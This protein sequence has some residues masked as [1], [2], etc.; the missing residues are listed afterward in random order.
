MFYPKRQGPPGAAGTPGAPGQGVPTGGTPGQY[1]RKV[2]LTD[3]A[4]GWA[5]ASTISADLGLGTAAFINTGASAGNVV[6]LNGSAQLPAVDGSLLTNLPAQSPY[7]ADSWDYSW[8]AGA[9]TMASDGWTVVGSPTDTSDTIGGVT[10]R[11][12]TPPAGATA[13]YVYKDMTTPPVGSYEWR[14]L[15]YM[16]SATT[17]VLYS[18]G[19]GASASG[20][21]KRLTLAVDSAGLETYASGAFTA[22]PPMGGLV[23]RWIWITVRVFNGGTGAPGRAEIWLGGCLGWSGSTSTWNAISTAG[24]VEFG[25]TSAHSG[26][27]VCVISQFMFR[28][29]INQAPPDYTFRALSGEVGP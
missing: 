8:T 26:T 20:V 28:S 11:A 3:Y 4:T 29:G 23:G 2:G 7:T 21:N 22:T 1:L 19:F 9:G 15:V 25:K 14:A 18:L 10:G 24:R 17:S 5:G 27:G 13:A 12:I 16:P 6:A